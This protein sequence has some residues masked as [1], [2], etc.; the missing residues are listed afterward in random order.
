MTQFCSFRGAGR[1]ISNH[2]MKGSFG[3]TT[4]SHIFNLDARNDD[5]PAQVRAEFPKS[6]AVR[7]K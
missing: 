5:D 1:I 2:D 6:G 7:L 4:D 3:A